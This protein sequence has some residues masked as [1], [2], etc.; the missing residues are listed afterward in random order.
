MVI[1]VTIAGIISIISNSSISSIRVFVVVQIAIAE[2]V[3]IFCTTV[4]AARFVTVASVLIGSCVLGG[5]GS[6]SSSSSVGVY[7]GDLF[8]WAFGRAFLCEL[9]LG[10]RGSGS[11]AIS[12]VY[13]YSCFVSHHFLD[14][15]VLLCILFSLE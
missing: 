5:G 8:F 4:K 15:T 1:G 9:G 6:S 14:L 7:T 11:S 2:I 3:Q 13:L 12:I 10:H